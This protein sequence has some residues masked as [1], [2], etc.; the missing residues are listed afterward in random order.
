MIIIYIYVNVIKWFYESVSKGL[1]A[2]V[3]SL[4]L[5]HECQ[6][7]YHAVMGFVCRLDFNSN[8]LKII[9]HKLLTATYVLYLSG[10]ASDMP[11]PRLLKF[12]V[13]SIILDRV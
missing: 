4:L 7:A 3:L 1:F 8:I 11:L 5:V 10:V 2:L 13:V 6:K 9:S 12:N